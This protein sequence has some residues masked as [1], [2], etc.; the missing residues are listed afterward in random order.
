MNRFDSML[1]VVGKVFGFCAIV[2]ILAILAALTAIACLFFLYLIG[3]MGWFISILILVPML[4]GARTVFVLVSDW[5]EAPKSFYKLIFLKFLAVFLFLL[6]ASLGCIRTDCF[7]ILS[8][9]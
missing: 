5:I 7:I 3:N 4:V 9:G 6:L 1:Q 8:P 2:L